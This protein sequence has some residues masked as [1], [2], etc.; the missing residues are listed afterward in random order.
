[1]K[2]RTDTKRFTALL[3]A[4]LLLLTACGPER[5]PTYSY[6][7][8]TKPAQTSAA[9]QEPTEST[10]ANWRTEARGLSDVPEEVP[11]WP[12]HSAALDF[13]PAEGLRITA[14]AGALYDDTEIT[15]TPVTGEDERLL[16][17]AEDFD[18]YGEPVIGIWEVH[19]GLEPDEHLPGTYTVSIDLAALDVDESLWSAV[20]LYRL[21][22]DD[23]LTAYSTRLE[24]SILSY[25]TSQNSVTFATICEALLASKSLASFVS[26]I[27][28]DY[29]RQ[30]TE[31]GNYLIKWS[32]KDV[33]P[34]QQEKWEKMRTITARHKAVA[35]QDY[36]KEA[37]EYE[38]A[39]I[40]LRLYHVN[41]S[42]EKRTLE[43]LQKDEEFIK[44][45]Q[46]IQVPKLIE[47]VSKA[48]RTAY[49]YLGEWRLSRMPGHEV[50]FYI[51]HLNE[52]GKEPV[53]GYSV[54]PPIGESYIEINLDLII[55]LLKDGTEGT[56]IK[57]NMLLTVTHE[58]FHICQQEYHYRNIGDSDRY[59][60][61]TALLV[62]EEAKDWYKRH[63]IITT[64]PELTR[65][66]HWSTLRLPIDKSPMFS[67]ILLRHQGYLLSDFVRYLRGKTGQNVSGVH[68]YRIRCSYTTPVTSKALM[69]AFSLSEVSFDKYFRQFCIDHWENFISTY[70]R[71]GEYKPYP[72]LRLKKDEGIHVSLST[73]GSYSAGVRCFNMYDA[74][75]LPLLMVMDD[76]L[77][78]E[79][80]EFNLV[81]GEKHMATRN[82][83][84]LP[85]PEK[86]YSP[87][88][89]RRLFLE[90][91]GKLGPNTGTESG[92]T[93]W[94]LDAPDDPV[95]ECTDGSLNVQF[96]EPRGA[97]KA[98]LMDG[99]LLKV[100]SDDG[101]ETLREYSK[102]CFGKRITI[103]LR[104]LL[105]DGTETATLTVSFAEFV[106][107]K[108]DEACPGCY[109]K[110]VKIPV[111]YQVKSQSFRFNSS[112]MK[113][114]PDELA[115]P[116]LRA[117]LQNST[118]Y[119]YED[120]SFTIS[121]SGKASREPGNAESSV[122]GSAN[123]SFVIKGQYDAK[124]GTGTATI[125]GGIYHK[126]HS[127]YTWE[128]HRET[129]HVKNDK[130]QSLTLL[131]VIR[132]YIDEQTDFTYG[133][134]GS[135][136]VKAVD[137]S[138][139]IDGLILTMQTHWTRSGE[140]EHWEWETK[141]YTGDPETEF[142]EQTEKTLY[143]EDREKDP[144]DEGWHLCWTAGEHK[145]LFY[146]SPPMGY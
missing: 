21:A 60:E 99:L 53:Y 136:T 146:D 12:Y 144:W 90:I 80:P 91:Y 139:G 2:K 58:L 122:D 104:E 120:G 19:A 29:L 59:D 8:P 51:K 72:Q 74:K 65:T 100:V 78:A 33:D 105:N 101:K 38:K 43:Y 46:S 103:P 6:V 34:E 54:T 107:S 18:T 117:A 17:L 64:E 143:E 88:Q 119:L 14:E 102:D 22:D 109:S 95:L 131:Y 116:A 68:I 48:I 81:C 106:Y 63:D 77:A 52:E 84:Y 69:A 9:S 83:A 118:L 114:M 57:D 121:G 108:K 61:M 37:K 30:E 70:V 142:H 141:D 7:F 5:P 125:S 129:A 23:T 56:T 20:R 128:K 41:K 39:D 127:L 97:A 47:A 28:V 31:Y 85:G 112:S 16:K 96:P 133:F 11:E 98:G 138:E 124:T 24:G 15:M 113:D 79:H 137:P 135:G 87:S 42:V 110:E 32:V 71:E 50:T 45:V 89:Y 94:S 40:F 73:E 86:W 1:M 134:S 123:A 126:D 3:L 35:Q 132:G 10:A 111:D 82:G 44:L 26:Q 92:Y 75:P 13:V 66:D 67:S 76:N 140:W 36:E 55:G 25:T 62:E 115:H 145:P 93:V 27:G 4:F 49:E 130:G